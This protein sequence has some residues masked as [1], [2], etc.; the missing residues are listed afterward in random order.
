MT[1]AN[2]PVLILVGRL[3]PHDFI[4]NYTKIVGTM[5]KGIQY[6]VGYKAGHEHFISHSHVSTKIKLV[7]LKSFSL[8]DLS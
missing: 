5:E 4:W 8:E 7:R 3:F 6:K 1:V 2:Q